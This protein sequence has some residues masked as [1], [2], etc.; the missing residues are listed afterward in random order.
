MRRAS[1]RKAAQHE[2][3]NILD[4]IWFIE[5]FMSIRSKNQNIVPF[6]LNPIQKHY[7][8]NRSFIKR[9]GRGKRDVIIKARQHG[10]TSAVVAEYL[11]DTITNEGTTTAIIGHDERAMITL[12]ENVRI[13]IKSLEPHIVLSLG[14]D[15]DGE[16]FFDKLNSRMFI[17]TYR[18]MTA[19][20]QTVHNLL[21]T[22]VAFW[23]YYDLDN[24]LAG[25][26][27]AVPMYG[28]ITIE[29][30]PNGV[31]GFFFDVIQ[32]A[33]E[34]KSV[35]KYFDFPWFVNSEYRLPE[36]E[37]INLPEIIR[38]H[39]G[40]PFD[41]QLDQTECLLIEKW[42]LA[43]EQIMWRRYKMLSMNDMRLS[44]KGIKT[45]RKFAQEYECEFHASGNTVFDSTYLIPSA[46]YQT[47][48]IE[49]RYVHGA[50]TSEGVEDGDFSVLY[51]LDLGTGEV[52]N[53]IRGRFK[54][55][56]FAFEIHR[57]CMRYGGLVGVENNNTGHAVL[58]KLAE[59][60]QDELNFSGNERLPY[61]IF[62]D[63][64]LGWSTNENTRKI[65]LIELDE[66]FRSGNIKLA[67]ED[68]DG[69]MEL[70]AFQYN[71]DMKEVAPE[72]MHDDSV[73]ALAICWQMRK[74]YAQWN[75]QRAGVNATVIG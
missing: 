32:G 15:N 62:Y 26:T 27:E 10:I 20:S 6:I 31:G 49:H 52:V 72:G 12:L 75:A 59:L 54:P 69:R 24:V 47:P 43:P 2:Q 45:S 57:T 58:L 9:P 44:E 67:K 64:K 74:Y 37:W 50:D 17:Q 18:Q 60:Y 38:I 41:K 29:S 39:S 22:E 16:I 55:R 40:V 25:V 4:P 46:T 11:H 70:L 34:G 61:G 36:A 35:Y 14:R 21:L 8:R 23:Q 5:T 28:N 66:A 7:L 13:M 65:M 53:K 42:N 3:E 68:E 71:A 73:I 33:M 63:K 51:T 1:K 48:K 19:R 56:D 30:T